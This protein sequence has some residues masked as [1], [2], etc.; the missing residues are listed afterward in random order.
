MALNLSE[1]IHYKTTEKREPHLGVKNG[2][3]GLLFA[4]G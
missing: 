3:L 1:L 2:N 4:H